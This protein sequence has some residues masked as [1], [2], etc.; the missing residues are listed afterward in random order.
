MADNH[1]AAEQDMIA[2][3]NTNYHPIF[4][5]S[6]QASVPEWLPPMVVAGVLCDLLLAVA[7]LMMW[8]RMRRNI[9]L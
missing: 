7:V 9:K 6:Q 4:I 3:Y 1:N 2:P 5:V 8:R